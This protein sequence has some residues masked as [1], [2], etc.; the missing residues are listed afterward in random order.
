MAMRATITFERY[1]KSGQLLERRAQPSRS[2]LLGLIQM[3]YVHHSTLS[4]SSGV[5][6]ILFNHTAQGF[7]LDTHYHNFRVASLGGGAHMPTEGYPLGDEIGI[8][9]G[10]GTSAVDARD[11]GLEKRIAPVEGRQL[12]TIKHPGTGN[13]Y[14]LAFD[15]TDFYVVDQVNPQSKIYRFNRY[16][17]DPITS[18]NAPGDS[19]YSYNK[20]LCFD[21]TYLWCTGRVT[22]SPYYKVFKLDKDTGAVISEWFTQFGNRQC[23]GLAW[24]GANIWCADSGGTYQLHK[25]NPADGSIVASISPPYAGAYYGLAWMGPISGGLP[26]EVPG[27]DMAAR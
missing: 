7:T 6:Q 9:I 1:S 20:G 25:C 24:D 17:G 13:P 16:T 27:G 19:Q 4:L 12:Y 22:V 10:T 14:G 15:N 18:Y 11:R 8:Q 23:N 5:N 21:G 3:L 2:F 26:R